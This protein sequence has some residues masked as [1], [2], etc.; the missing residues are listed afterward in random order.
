MAKVHPRVQESVPSRRSDRPSVEEIIE[1]YRERRSR[2]IL[3]RKA[4]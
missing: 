2:L 4:R 1:E 3:G